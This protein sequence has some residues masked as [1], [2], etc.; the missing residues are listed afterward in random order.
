MDI[1]RQYQTELEVSMSCVV[2]VIFYGVEIN[3]S[4]SWLPAEFCLFLI[5]ILII[6][7]SEGS[8]HGEALFKDN[9]HVGLIS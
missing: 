5:L 4:A 9:F 2:Y 1:K 8:E 7:R 3:I 6:I